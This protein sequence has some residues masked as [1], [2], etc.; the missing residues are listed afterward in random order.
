[1]I[2]KP[3]PPTTNS[4]TIHIEIYRP[5]LTNYTDATGTVL[6]SD[7]HFL[8]LYH[9][10]ANYLSAT[11]LTSYSGATY[12]KA[13]T[14]VLDMYAKARPNRSFVPTYE[15]AD[16]AMTQEFIS[17]LQRQRIPCQLLPPY[18]HRSNAAERAI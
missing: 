5:T 1:M 14:S 18:N 10:D 4:D 6:G 3:S 11:P 17:Y 9:F 8:I 12:M 13:Y 2:S 7:L 15:K 16:N